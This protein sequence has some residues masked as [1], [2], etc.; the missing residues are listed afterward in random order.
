MGLFA[1]VAVIS[2]YFAEAIPIKGCSDHYEYCGQWAKNHYC[3]LDDYRPYMKLVCPYSCGVC[4][5]KSYV[6]FIPFRV[7]WSLNMSS[8]FTFWF[9]NECEI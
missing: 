7:V 5:G 2:F 1:F 8:L 6:F 9:M 4:D 3:D